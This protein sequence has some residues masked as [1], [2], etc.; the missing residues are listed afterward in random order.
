MSELA[1]WQCHK[2]V[3]AGEIVRIE[4]VYAHEG[5]RPSAFRVHC[6]GSSEEA[7]VVIKQVPYGV[8][9]RLIAERSSTE[10]ALGAFLV[11]YQDGHVS[12]SPKGAFEEGY[13]RL[14]VEEAGGGYSA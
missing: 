1:S 7:G 3:K 2:T 10:E 14:G 5:A 9:A 6:K 8:F 13:K 12:W 11:V 4:A